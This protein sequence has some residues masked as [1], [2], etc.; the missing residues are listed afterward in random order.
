MYLLS[1]IFLLKALLYSF[2]ALHKL[3]YDSVCISSGTSKSSI[4]STTS[5][6]FERNLNTFL[7]YKSSLP[8]A[9]LKSSSGKFLF[10]VVR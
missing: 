7:L 10:N 6:K 8:K 2:T 1:D 4:L 9:F 3:S 5:S